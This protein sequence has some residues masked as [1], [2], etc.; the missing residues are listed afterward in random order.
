MSMWEKNGVNYLVHG[1]R[2]TFIVNLSWIFMKLPHFLIGVTHAYWDSHTLKIGQHQ[3]VRKLQQ[4]NG[5]Q[6]CIMYTSLCEET[7]WCCSM[8]MTYKVKWCKVSGR[9]HK[10]S[11]QSRGIGGLDSWIPWIGRSSSFK[12][13]LGRYKI[14]W[15]F[16]GIWTIK[17]ERNYDKIE[18]KKRPISCHDKEYFEAVDLCIRCCLCGLEVTFHGTIRTQC[19]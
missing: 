7:A 1:G 6:R 19:L 16:C 4:T 17:K 11:C 3:D 2:N 12:P 14:P 5:Y 18:I 8:V 10:E 13:T 15:Q 9:E